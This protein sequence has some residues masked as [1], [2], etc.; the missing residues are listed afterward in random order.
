[1]ESDDDDETKALNLECL[2]EH[3]ETEVERLR[4]FEFDK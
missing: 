1:V 2:E 3:R 4:E